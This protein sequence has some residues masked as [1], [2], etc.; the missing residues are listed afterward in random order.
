MAKEK[1]NFKGCEKKW[2]KYWEENE[3]FKTNVSKLDEKTFSIDTPPPTVSGK[4]HIGHVFSYSQQDFIARFQRMKQGVVFFPFGTDDNG[5]PTERLVEKINKVKSPEMSRKDFIQLCQKTLK[6]ETP[7]YIQDWKD[8]GMSCDFGMFYSTID[9]NTQRI[10]QKYFI[11][12]AKKGIIYQKEFPTIWCPECQTAI[13]QAELEDKDIASKF[14]TLK[15][16]V[17]ETGEDL[18][19]ST[20]RP[21]LLGACVCVF[22]NPKDK[23]Y[24]SFVGKTALTPLFNQE[25]PILEDDSAQI[26]KGTGVLMVCSY[27]DKFDLEAIQRFNLEPK[28]VFNKDG[29]LNENCKG[30]EGLK[31]KDARGKILEDLKKKNLIVEQKEINHIVNCHDKCG[32]EIEFIPT[33]QWFVNVLDNKEKL[34]EQGKKISW[35][36]EFMF[37]RYENWVKGLEWDWNISRNRHFGISIPVWFCENCNEAIYPEEK[38]LPV[39]PVSLEKKCLKCGKKAIP[40]TMVLDTWATSSLTPQIGS[41]LVDGKVEVPFSLRPQGHDIIRTWAFYTIVRSFYHN[42]L[43]PWKNIMV[44]GNVSLG[45]EKM[46]KSKG[47]VITP[48][49]VV[50]K[51]CADALRFW[52]SGSTLGSDLDYQESS[53]VNATKLLNKL[54]NASRFVFMNLSD[55]D[56]KSRPETLELLDEVFLKRL[57]SLVKEATKYFEDYE[58]SK[59]KALT[60]QFFWI[61][62]CDNY[63]EIVKKRVYQGEGDKKLSAQYTLYN[64]L[65]TLVKL[66]A[67]F[68]PFTTE[69]IYQENFKKFEG[70]KSIHISSWPEGKEISNL[71]ENVFEILVEVLGKIRQ[72]KTKA[73]KAMNCEINLTLSKEIYFRLEGVLEDLKNV[74]NAREILSG[75]DLRVEF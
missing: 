6:I 14:S 37:K 28:I 57:N 49:E 4:M 18:L 40:E 51:Y 70:D 31:I 65:L 23:R 36:P 24:K 67:P 11:D 73:Q 33:K 7:K 61:D 25:V 45:G 13:A 62:F 54:L 2:M 26:D 43:I 34:I 53:L 46:S 3:I 9:F 8:I 5:L 68:I 16:K 66:F 15:F 42:D 64:S 38:E 55:Y 47:N 10:S 48:Q 21:E 44:S 72:E 52:A 74:V 32:N 75:K 59:S 20:T 58:Y 17:K 22:V 35:R 27:G 29:T 30:Y 39:D 41:S 60:E 50:E 1:F 19:I 71:E 63:L 69:E 12:L 56:G